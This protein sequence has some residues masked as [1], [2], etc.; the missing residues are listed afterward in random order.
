MH[1][2]HISRGQ[3]RSPALSRMEMLSGLLLYLAV[4]VNT[5]LD[6]VIGS[7]AE[8]RFRFPRIHSLMRQLP[9]S[10]FHFNAP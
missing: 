8:N 4:K 10:V 7:R 5:A 6:Q 2:C 9:A 1:S 3:I